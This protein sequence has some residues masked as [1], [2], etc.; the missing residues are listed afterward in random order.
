MNNNVRQ[1]AA[2]FLQLIILVFLTVSHQKVFQYTYDN[3]FYDTDPCCTPIQ[4]IMLLVLIQM[5]NKNINYL[6]FHVITQHNSIW[7][8][9]LYCVVIR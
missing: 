8:L 2:S 5:K 7:M 9:S 3:T 1:I 6:L 4:V